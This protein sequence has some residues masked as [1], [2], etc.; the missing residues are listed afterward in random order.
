M[1]LQKLFILNSL[2]YQFQKSHSS[3]PN[4]QLNTFKE[5]LSSEISSNASSV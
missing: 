5:L 3:Q 1:M 2:E 4:L